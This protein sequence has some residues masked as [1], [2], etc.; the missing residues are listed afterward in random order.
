[1]LSVEC[2]EICHVYNKTIEGLKG[3]RPTEHISLGS[4]AGKDDA[5]VWFCSRYLSL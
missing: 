1:V 4:Y 2:S 5:L 3:Y